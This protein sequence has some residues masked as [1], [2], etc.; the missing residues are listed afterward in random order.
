MK[1][2][3]KNLLLAS[4]TA[5][6]STLASQSALAVPL[7]W[8]G[9]GAT[10]GFGTAGGSWSSQSL[11]SGA[12]GWS[13]ASTGNAAVSA[14]QATSNAD[15]FNFGSA[16]N[17]LAT[18]SI[19]IGGT[20]GTPINVGSIVFE[21]TSGAITLSG[22]FLAFGAS[23]VITVNNTTNT[24]SS[25]IQ[26][27]NGFIK[28]GTGELI[29]TGNNTYTGLTTVQGTGALTLSGDNIAMIGGVTLSTATSQNPK[30]NINSATAIGT[31][32]L[33]FGGGGASD[34][35]TINNTSGGAVALTT[36]NAMT[37]NRN[38]TFTG[39]NSLNLGN[40][41][42][43]LGGM[44]TGSSRSI[45]VGSNTLTLAGIVTET[46]PG[47][48]NFGI[49]LGGNGTLALTNAANT[50]TGKTVIGNNVGSSLRLQVSK[51]ANLGV[52]SSLGAPAT[53]AL[54]LIQ[55]G[56]GSNSST[57]ELVG[58]T[59]ASTTNRQIQ[60]GS[61]AN[62]SGNAFIQNNNTNAA[63]TLTF[64]NAAFNVAATG[65]T[66]SSRS[67]QLGGSNTGDNTISGAIIPNTGGSGTTGLVK[68]GTG[69]WV[70]N[71]TSSFT[72][73]VSVQNGI[74]KINSIKD[75]GTNSAAGAGVTIALGTSTTGTLVYTGSGDSTNRPI[76]VGSATVG[77]TGGGVINNDGSGAL[78]FTAAAFNSAAAGVTATRNL[79]LGGTYT[80]G[81][82]EI[83]GS[84]VNNDT[85]T[86]GIVSVT[87]NGASTW[88]FSGTSTYT[89]ATTVSGGILVL[90]AATSIQNSAFDTASIAGD[91]TN[92]L[93]T[94]VTTLTLGGLTGGNNFAT[95]FT[96]TTGG[97]TGL[98]SLTLNPGTGVT[99]SYSG[100][101]GDGATGMNLTKTGAGT[102]TLTG[103]NTHSGST[104][105]TAG[106]LAVNGTLANTS[107]TTVSGTGTLKGSGSINSS[108]TINSGGTL[109]S[110]TSIESLAVDG[111][112]SF[113]TASSFEYE[114][115]KDV[116][117]TVAGDL[118][119]ATGSLSLAGTVTLNL[120][121][122]GVGSWELGTPLGDPFGSPA[123]DKLTLISYNGTWNGGLFTYLGNLVAD[124][125]SIVLNGQKWFFNYNDTAAGTNYTGDL[126]AA[127]RFVTMTVP[128]PRAALLGGLGLLAL[129]RRRR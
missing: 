71:G 118:T 26:G 67:L 74:L 15:T 100:D 77:E 59:S 111:D 122:S 121:E 128:E 105:V 37:L 70:L 53:A 60:I 62:G 9:D 16:T 33:S 72:G 48:S 101:I 124:D 10:L 66:S 104:S 45:S 41:T 103:T 8:D 98:T 4:F 42:A 43:T 81:I 69:T 5:I 6:I 38:F 57:L 117:A 91:A 2:N 85:G 126:G 27:S 17:G 55:I 96:S 36:T 78:T 114:L 46:T 11:T 110:G 63:H 51:L 58:G 18:G 40:G 56:S 129:L 61:S 125:S 47:T 32:T 22:G 52:A 29:L 119:A 13:T 94:T 3:H 76:R 23:K 115:D 99:N 12:G 95:R 90:S 87:K 54:G 82:N 127:T 68:N 30:L 28:N 35:V 116:A 89:G 108:V 107:T 113:T 49:T 92:G 44:T 25:V 31:G 1:L 112:L 24:I 20:S 93:R 50:Y 34:P 109:A 39:S 106:V 120:I 21:S 75:S 65:V 19:T 123:A 79:T 102:Q 84:I 83:Q 7:Y 73:A 97:Y 86:G 80:G 88:Q 64:S 14:S